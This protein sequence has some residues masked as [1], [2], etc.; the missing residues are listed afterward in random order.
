MNI[1]QALNAFYKE[2]GFELETGKRPAFV[3]VFVGCLLIPL[4][5]VE[6]RRKYIK[7]HDLHHVITGY[8]ASQVGEG[9]VSAWE[10]GTGSMLHP[11]LMFMNLIAISTAMAVSPRRVFK[12]YLLG[13]KSRNLYCPKVRRR[14]DNGELN[15]IAQL[16]NEFVNCRCS[17]GWIALKM[18]P[19]V[20]YALLS[21]IIHLIL[22][23]PAL[24]YKK[25]WGKLFSARLVKLVKVRS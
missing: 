24:L 2:S 1:E 19:F 20:L 6:T 14:I 10:L 18:I 8:G 22:V 15:D 7:Y 3:E 4:P 5:N 13:C 23:I 12:A 16:R 17:D 9:E 21:I 11:I 25:V